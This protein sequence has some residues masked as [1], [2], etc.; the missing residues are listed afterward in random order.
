LRL[1][2]YARPYLHVIAVAVVFSLL[3]GGGI[4]GRAY[5]L[6]PVIDDVALPN[7]SLSS[8]DELREAGEVDPAQAELERAQLAER[9]RENFM[10]VLLAGVV[11]VFFMPAVRLFRDYASDWLMNR[12]YVDLQA[13]LGQKLLRLPLGH[14]VRGASGDF[15]SRVSNDTK[16]ANR[17]QQLVFGEI[18]HDSSMMLVALSAAI[19]LNWQLALVLFGIGPPV[20]LILRGFGKRIRR[21]SRARQEQ[22]SDVTQRLVRMLSGIKVIKAFHAEDKESAAYQRSVMRYFKRSMRLVRNRVLSRSLV[23][24]ASQGSFVVVLM[25]GVWAVLQGV[26]GLTLGNLAAFIAISAMLYRPIRSVTSF[27]NHIQAAVPAGERIFE[28]LDADEMPGDDSAAVEIQRISQGIRYRGVRFGYGREPVLRSVDLEISAGEIVALV[29]HTGSGKTTIADLLLR[30]WD[31]DE[32]T[33]EIDGVDTRKIRRASLHE[34]IAVVTQEPFLFDASI[35]AN[36]RYGKR[37]ASHEEVVAAARAAF[38]HEFIDALPD[39]YDTEVGEYGDQ[40][41]GG[42]RQRLT[43]AR[44]ILRDPQLLIFDEATSALDAKVEGML[45]QA[46]ANLMRGRTVLLIAHR[47]STVKNADKIAVVEAGR[48]VDT[49]T[50]DDLM[51]QDGL[52]RELVDLQL[53]DTET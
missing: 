27:Y 26:W 1:L 49:G 12:L 4:T 21:A 52:Y 17:A 13:D 3:Y 10:Q 53:S 32:G 20:V 36:I 30:F 42:Q 43:I 46:V 39:G 44:A 47:L 41:S 22:V 19:W 31:P 2:R 6:A 16:V 48:V 51:K 7:A 37:D 34:M 45:Q 35:S 50:H 33:I 38:A 14:H 15:I 23:E 40:L 28:I 24:L 18:L 8:L 9:V 5:L 11:L 25:V 29:G